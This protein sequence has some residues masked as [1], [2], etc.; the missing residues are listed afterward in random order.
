MDDDD[1][2]RARWQLIGVLKNLVIARTKRL[3]LESDAADEHLFSKIPRD[4]QL[5]NQLLLRRRLRNDARP[6]SELS[7][8]EQIER[9][10]EQQ[11]VAELEA[12]VNLGAL[13][14]PDHIFL[15]ALS[16]AAGLLED[17]DAGDERALSQPVTLAGSVVIAFNE[18]RTKLGRNPTWRQVRDLVQRWQHEGRVKP[19]TMT[20][21]SW[22]KVKKAPSIAALFRKH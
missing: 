4:V 22:Q 9:E 14:K 11:V 7:A 13:T 19:V 3:L 16:K 17:Y 1:L 21:R 2:T 8:G 18:L 12:A 10:A 20:E 5:A 6:L 15:R